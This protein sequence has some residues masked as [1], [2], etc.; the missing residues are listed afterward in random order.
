MVKQ[1]QKALRQEVFGP[2]KPIPKDV[3]MNI[4]QTTGIDVDD[5]RK[6]IEDYFVPHIEDCVKRFINFAKAIPGFNQ[7][8]LDDQIALIKGN[9]HEVECGQRFESRTFG[10]SYMVISQT[11]TNRTNIVNK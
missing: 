8:G 3:Y 11:A 4:Y 2:M 10:R 9:K 7:L 6:M 5:R 1:E